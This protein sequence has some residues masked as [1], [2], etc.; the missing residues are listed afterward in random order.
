[1]ED[2]EL[3]VKCKEHVAKAR[4]KPSV[5]EATKQFHKAPE[6]MIA[7]HNKHREE[8][9]KISEAE[10]KRLPRTSAG[11]MEHCEIT[12]WFDN[13]GR[14]GYKEVITKFGVYPGEEPLTE[15]EKEEVRRNF[16]EWVKA[17]IAKR[18]DDWNAFVGEEKGEPV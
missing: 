17:S 4:R 9:Y 16:T 5:V 15:E 7:S 8:G 6:E 12:E 10:V 3:F 1:M 18:W 11:R 2:D 13:S 14:A